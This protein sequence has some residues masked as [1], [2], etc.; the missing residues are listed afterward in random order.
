M[1]HRLVLG[2][3]AFSLAALG[4]QAAAPTAPVKVTGGA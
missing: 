4:A 2:A 3:A 1:L